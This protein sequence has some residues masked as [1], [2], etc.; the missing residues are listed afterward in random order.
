[1]K[2]EALRTTV[3]RFFTVIKSR[4]TTHEVFFLCPECGD[5][6]GNRSVSTVNGKTFCW[7]CDK[8]GDFVIW[9]R[10]LGYPIEPETPAS[11]PLDAID[12]ATPTPRRDSLP[13]VASVDLPDG[14]TYCAEKPKSVYTSLIGE[15]ALAKNLTLADFIEAKAGFTKQDTRWEPYCIFPVTEY[16]RTV[17][18][19]GRTYVDVPGES[20]KKFPNNKEVRFGSKYWLYNIDELKEKKASIVLVVESILNVLSLRWL[21]RELGIDNIV[22][23][24]SFTHRISKWQA[25]KLLKHTFVKEVCLLFDHDATGLSWDTASPMAG[26]VK[27]TV[28]EMPLGPNNEKYD[29]NDDVEAAYGAFVRR[30]VYSDAAKLMHV[31]GNIAGSRHEGASTP[32]EVEKSYNFLD[33]AVNVLDSNRTRRS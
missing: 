15:M 9:A 23:V 33:L 19:Q 14:F 13:P 30:K 27:M 1:M 29:P 21:F 26:R 17:Y 24:G 11:L 25:E 18:Y 22:P 20:T 2:G 16:G 3:N 8:G 12:M 4:S 28:A 7:R 32:Q 10:H 6:T 5:E 31:T